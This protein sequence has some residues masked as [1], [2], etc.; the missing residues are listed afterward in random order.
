MML[1]LVLRKMRT[2]MIK[3]IKKAQAIFHLFTKME[4]SYQKPP[5]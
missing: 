3:K 4:T 2:K 5:S 1:V